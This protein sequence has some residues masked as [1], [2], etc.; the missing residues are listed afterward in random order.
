MWLVI[1]TITIFTLYRNFLIFVIIFIVSTTILCIITYHYDDADEGGG[2]S[3]IDCKHDDDERERDSG[4]DS[5][6]TQST[7]STRPDESMP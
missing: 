6:R 3:C 2:D 1:T 7:V 4:E 5:N